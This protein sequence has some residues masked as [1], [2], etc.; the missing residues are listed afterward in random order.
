MGNPIESACLRSELMPVI[1]RSKDHLPHGSLDASKWLSDYAQRRAEATQ[2]IDPE[3]TGF[4]S[5]PGAATLS[6]RG[7]MIDAC[8]IRAS[9]LFHL[10]ENRRHHQTAR[11]V[12]RR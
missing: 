3:G 10:L 6:L 2:C 9:Q 7:H 1:L 4:V 11:V 8:A 5:L 12:L